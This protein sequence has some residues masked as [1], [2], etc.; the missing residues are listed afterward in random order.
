M[1]LIQF[2]SEF[3]SLIA[4]TYTI[5]AG[6]VAIGIPLSIQF[7]AQY[8][9]KH[10][11]ALLSTRLTRGKYVNPKSILCL[12]FLYM[13]LSLYY[14]TFSSSEYSFLS[15]SATHLDILKLCLPI[16]FA[17]LIFCTFYFYWRLF[18]KITVKSSLQIQS[19]LQMDV[20]QNSKTKLFKK[21]F[22]SP[23]KYLNQYFP[24]AA[25]YFNALQSKILTKKREPVDID[26]IN[27]GLELLIYNIEKRSWSFEFEAT[28]FQFDSS[29]HSRYFDSNFEQK[30]KLSQTDL[31]II[32]SYWNTLL[33]LVKHARKNE[34]I[35]MSFQTQRLIASLISK[36]IYHPMRASIIAKSFSELS[37]SKINLVQDVYELARWQEY[38]PN[39]GIDLILEC[40]WFD[41][42]FNAP[43]NIDLKNTKNSVE[44]LIYPYKL[45]VDIF[46]LIVKYQPNTAIK[47]VKNIS[48]AATFGQEQQ[49]IFYYSETRGTEWL[50]DYWRDFNK[51]TFCVEDIDKLVEKVES[52]KNGKAFEQYR[53]SASSKPLSKQELDCALSK[54]K[55]DEIFECIHLKLVKRMGWN[56]SASLA[57]YERWNEFYECLYW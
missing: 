39:K 50:A 16:I 31:I 11:N 21:L 46:D 27:A 10:D 24:W 26:R 22:K 41:S 30:H 17:A 14:L 52:L 32:K 38:Q 19:Y 12:S 1:Y 43:H 25:K 53:N 35:S 6:F 4:H 8:S 48:Q 57:Y 36:I 47:F 49:F 7:S 29:I 56:I 33:R 13:A 40:E 45:A 2:A 5:I 28:L 3:H 15:L 34:D 44:G 51:I 37:D 20:K 23:F 42:V 18:K 9:D 55:L 54:I